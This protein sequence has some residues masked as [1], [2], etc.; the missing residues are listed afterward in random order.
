[1]EWCKAKASAGHAAGAKA[2]HAKRKAETEAAQISRAANSKA[3]EKKSRIEYHDPETLAR[4]A[5][6][7]QKSG[8]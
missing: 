2:M 1:L 7:Q 8:G 5:E 4:I 3:K 6:E